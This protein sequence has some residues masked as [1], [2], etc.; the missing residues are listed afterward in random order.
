MKNL[1]ILL[2][3]ALCISFSLASAQIAP[4][5]EWQN[6]IG[7]ISGD[8]LYSVIE[9]IDGGY[10]LGGTSNSG[11]SGDKTDTKQ[12]LMIIGL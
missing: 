3:L 6:T 11:I 9:T 12:G 2:T 4:E 1:N 7:G 8:F 10:L 5:I